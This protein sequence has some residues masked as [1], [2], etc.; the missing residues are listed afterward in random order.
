MLCSQ[1][2]QG[3]Q[4]G[5]TLNCDWAEPLTAAAEDVAAAV[6]SMEFSLAWFADPIFFGDYPQVMKEVRLSLI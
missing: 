3:G 4:I 2:Q 6:R 1:K 5:I